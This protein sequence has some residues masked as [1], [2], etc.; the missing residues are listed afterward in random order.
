M[1]RCKTP[2]ILRSEEYLGYAAT[3]KDE[4]NAADRRFFSS[5]LV[6]EVR[7]QKICLDTAPIIYF[8]DRKGGRSNGI[9]LQGKAYKRN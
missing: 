3:T 4:G 5:L 1:P 9:N 8:I 2:E 7:G 6:D